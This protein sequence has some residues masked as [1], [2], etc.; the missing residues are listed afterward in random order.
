MGTY[1]PQ[2]L[3]RFA[4]EVCQAE[5]VRRADAE[6]LADSLVQANLWGH[7]SHGVLRL[8]WYIDRLRS[9][10]MKADA[11][12]EL[13]VDAGAV[14]VIDG[15]D[16]IGQ[17][18]AA[19]AAD[20]AVA[21]ARV[22]GVAAVGVRNSNHFGTAAYFTR[23]VSSQGC[24]GLLTTN[25]SPAMAPWGGRVKAVGNNP[26]S[27]S[28][29]AGRYG[30]MTMDLANTAVARGK[31]YLARER[32]ETI[33]EGW[34]TDS[35]GQPTTDPTAAIEGLI[36]PMGGHKGYVISV[37]LDVL[38]GVLTGSKFGDGVHG[39]YE[40]LPRSG[41]GHL[42][43]ALH[44]EAFMAADVFERRMEDLIAQLKAVPTAP[45]SE[46]V[47][48]PGELEER[49]QQNSLRA[50]VELPAATVGTL[51]SLATQTDVAP[52]RPMDTEPV[53][54]SGSPP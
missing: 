41:S 5:G 48:F 9:G 6:L 50:G 38:S 8:S 22:H 7:H 13:A 17:T 27:V 52:P 39:P 35:T 21:R 33:P 16:G 49:S 15:R 40:P 20:E 3:V 47:S 14:A 54:A 51:R 1:N 18:M 10:A 42:M 4:T 37:M 24:V 2:D 43:V 11:R 28:A 25:A 34:A 26:W 32:G 12:P 29:P 23:R 31:I 46:D 53:P 19:R 45:G 30:A 44:V 36:L